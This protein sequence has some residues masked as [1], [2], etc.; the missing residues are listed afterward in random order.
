MGHSHSHGIDDVS[1]GNS[2]SLLKSHNAIL[3][4]LDGN[5]NSNGEIISN[6]NIGIDLGDSAFGRYHL[7]LSMTKR[8]LFTTGWRDTNGETVDSANYGLGYDEYSQIITNNDQIYTY[9][10]KTSIRQQEYGSSNDNCLV[11]EYLLVVPSN[12]DFIEITI[13]DF[14]YVLNDTSSGL[15]VSHWNQIYFYWC[16]LG[17]KQITVYWYLPN[18]C[19]SMKA[20]INSGNQIWTISNFGANGSNNG[21]S[22]LLRSNLVSNSVFSIF[23][24]G[25]F[26]AN[27][28]AKSDQNFPMNDCVLRVI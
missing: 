11:H 25:R 3:D 24:F 5:F 20:G 23:P 13:S 8:G 16:F 4:I 10:S 17:R 22:A 2:V 7:N 14:V 12:A 1:E 19:D 27:F 9:G 21:K 26:K 28:G 18:N 6:N 15:N